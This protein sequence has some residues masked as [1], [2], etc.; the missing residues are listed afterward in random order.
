MYVFMMPP[1]MFWILLH[2]K[3]WSGDILVYHLMWAKYMKSENVKTFP[4]RSGTRQGCPLL[5]LLCTI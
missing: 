2:F 5:S 1:T 4:L 3:R